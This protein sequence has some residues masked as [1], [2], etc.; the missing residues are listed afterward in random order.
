MMSTSLRPQLLAKVWVHG[1]SP[2]G[3]AARDSLMFQRLFLN[4]FWSKHVNKPQ[5]CNHFPFHM[6][7]PPCLA[8]ASTGTHY[9]L[10]AGPT[11]L[12]V[13]GPEKTCPS[14]LDMTASALCVLL[15]LTRLGNSTFIQARECRCTHRHTQVHIYRL[16]M[17]VYTQCSLLNHA[18][19]VTEHT[20]TGPPNTLKSR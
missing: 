11:S 13:W 4:Y 9:T 18:S 12:P 19:W 2:S 20:C 16:C 6:S 5:D 1:V 10:P 8:T 14:L 15:A 7:Q 17:H 3:V